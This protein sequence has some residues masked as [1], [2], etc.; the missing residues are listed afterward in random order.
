[1]REST[2]TTFECSE[3]EAGG[4]EGEE[5]EEEGEYDEDEDEDEENETYLSPSGMSSSTNTISP[6]LRKKSI[7]SAH[8]NEEHSGKKMG[9]LIKCL[10]TVNDVHMLQ[11]MRILALTI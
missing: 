7:A 11:V 3:G 4:L 10:L 5:E 2:R 8:G 9:E 1:M 6:P